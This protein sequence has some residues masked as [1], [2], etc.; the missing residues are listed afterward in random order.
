MDV[1]SAEFSKPWI[2]YTDFM[3]SNGYDQLQVRTQC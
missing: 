2:Q 1:V 3:S